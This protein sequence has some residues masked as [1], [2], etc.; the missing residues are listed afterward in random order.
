MQPALLSPAAVTDKLQIIAGHADD[1]RW[2]VMS[3]DQPV[4][5][6]CGLR[7][8]GNSMEL[9]SVQLTEMSSTTL[10]RATHLVLTEAIAAAAEHH[11]N[12]IRCLV[13]EDNPAISSISL[14]SRGFER[15][16]SLQA[17][18]DSH[19]SVPE[20][21]PRIEHQRLTTC[22]RRYGKKAIEALVKNCLED[23]HDLRSLG[24][25]NPRCLLSAWMRR[26]GAEILLARSNNQMAGLAVV[27]RDPDADLI[28]LEYLGVA[29][30][31]RRQ[32]HARRLLKQARAM[33]N[34]EDGRSEEHV[35]VAYCDRNNTP[36]MQLYQTS[37]F[38][39][40][41]THTIWQL[42]RDVAQRMRQTGDQ[43]LEPESATSHNPQ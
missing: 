13:A 36:A 2:L 31:F 17:W 8:D 21:D 20:T 27:T 38:V 22:L 19:P 40:G 14:A 10:L 34:T 42:D 37:G 4:L 1:F 35:F 11:L 33:Q 43:T 7:V 23:S 12:W 25:V 3:N 16:D 24:P 5:E 9:V 28:T 41:D 18:K 32:G 26:R 6:I 29:R 30:P 15:R 39:P